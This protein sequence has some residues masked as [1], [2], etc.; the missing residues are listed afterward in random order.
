[1]WH[2]GSL[3]HGVYTQKFS[4]LCKRSRALN[5]VMMLTGWIQGSRTLVVLSMLKRELLLGLLEA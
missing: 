2:V 5:H 4:S 1:M 3:D